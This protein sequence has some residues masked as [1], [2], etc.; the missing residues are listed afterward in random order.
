MMYFH[1]TFHHTLKYDPQ[2]LT[3]Q[4]KVKLNSATSLETSM[5]ILWTF[6]IVPASSTI[7]VYQPSL[8]L[9]W[10]MSSFNMVK[11]HVDLVKKLS[12]WG[13]FLAQGTRR[14][15]CLELNYEPD[16][17]T[18]WRIILPLICQTPLKKKNILLSYL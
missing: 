12:R 11:S 18:F 1:G 3:Q 8:R 10:E 5:W 17:R 13:W 2:C 15:I 14:K 7:G 16:A 9:F 6:L 4:F